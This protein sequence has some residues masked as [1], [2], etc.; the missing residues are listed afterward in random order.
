MQENI[1]SGS[2]SRIDVAL[3][4]DSDTKLHTLDG[5][6]N[7]PQIPLNVMHSAVWPQNPVWNEPLMR[8]SETMT[9][10]AKPS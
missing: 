5:I 4:P 3:K 2:L 7:P 9:A 10:S 6:I 1:S 8:W